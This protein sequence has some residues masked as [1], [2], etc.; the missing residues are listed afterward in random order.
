MHSVLAAL[1]DRLED[2]TF[3]QANVIPWGSPVPSFGDLLRSTVATVGI[4]PSNREFV[5]ES[6]HELEGPIRR[7][8]TL[9]SLGLKSWAAA[10]ARHLGLIIG[11]CQT[12]FS[13]NPYDRW[14]KRLDEVIAGT[15]ASFYSDT[16]T[17][18]HLDLIPYATACKW[19]DLSP[20][21]R[22]SLMSA[23]GD[24]LGVLVRDSPVSVLILN[25]TSVVNQFEEI[26]GVSL[27]QL[28]MPSWSLSRQNGQDVAGTAY[29]G[30]IRTLAG[31]SLGRDV[32]V[33]GYNHNIQSSFGVTSVAVSA[34]RRWLAEASHE[35]L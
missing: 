32:L 9:R 5:D 31:V 26:S 27:E 25:G 15:G 30:R 29:R 22:V 10:D 21:Q 6:G 4:N 33:L 17:A 8:H 14:F 2:E 35:V 34:I 16:S 1:I 24:T 3:S 23:V 18:C 7:F 12:Y 13:G 28:S 19:N 20:R 11:S